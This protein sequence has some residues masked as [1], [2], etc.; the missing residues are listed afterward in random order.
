MPEVLA[1]V[2]SAFTRGFYRLALRAIDAYSIGVQYA[3]GME[4]HKQ[5]VHKSYLN[6]SFE[7]TKPE[8]L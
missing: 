1:S 7:G 2:S 6:I 5:K 3:S 8:E 4:K